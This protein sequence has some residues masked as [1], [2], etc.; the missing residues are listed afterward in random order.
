MDLGQ[1][2]HELRTRQNISL[3]ELALRAT[4]SAGFLSQI[5]NGKSDPSLTT[6]KKIADGLKVDIS[7]LFEEIKQSD[8]MLVKKGDRVCLNNIGEGGVSIEF[9]APFD[10]NN[11]MEACVHVVEANCKSGSQ[12]YA[13]DGQ[14]VFFVLEG[15]FKL[16]IGDMSFDMEKGDSYYLSNCQTAHM[17]ANTAK[18][19]K[20]IMLCVTN[21]PFFF[22]YKK[23][24]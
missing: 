15:Q 9:L 13:H 24:E 12:P 17:F 2:I 4:I 18:D 23:P 19:E 1:K 8:R 5:E 20:S 10:S 7:A 21:P 16:T 11:V 6:I 22:G 14:E 3:N